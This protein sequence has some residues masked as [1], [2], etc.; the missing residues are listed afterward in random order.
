[1]MQI[2][3]LERG[4]HIVVG[5]PGRVIDLIDRKKLK[6]GN[7][8]FMVLD[9]ADEMLNMGFIEDVEKIVKETP[10]ERRMLMF[11]ATMPDRILSLAKRHM[12]KF[13]MVSV[14]KEELTNVLIEQ[15]YYEVPN[16]DKFDALCRIIDVETDIYGIVFCNT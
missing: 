14:K 3:D 1:M 12:G 9:E 13:E 4:A 16:R 10:P 2:K 15:T 8:K 7:V 6:L 11:S 5:T